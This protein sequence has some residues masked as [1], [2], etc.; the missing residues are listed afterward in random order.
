MKIDLTNWIIGERADKTH[1]CMIHTAEPACV[2][3]LAEPG[4]D[5]FDTEDPD[6][7]VREL[8]WLGEPGDLDAMLAAAVVVLEIYDFPDEVDD[9]ED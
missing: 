9:E 6:I 2:I 4:E 5:G 1:W 8:Q 3:H 7:A